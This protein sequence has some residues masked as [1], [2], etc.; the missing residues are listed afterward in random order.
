MNDAVQCAAL[1]LKGGIVISA[2]RPARHHDLIRDLNRIGVSQVDICEAE[3]GFTTRLLPFVD[4][5]EARKIARAAGQIN[6]HTYNA[7]H[8]F[9]EDLY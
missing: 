3:Q 1:L 4:R 2:P 5:T 6:D 7:K 8:L 9:S